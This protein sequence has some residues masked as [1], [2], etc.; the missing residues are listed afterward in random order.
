MFRLK[1]PQLYINEIFSFFLTP[2]TSFSNKWKMHII[3]LHTFI[4]TW[5]IWLEAREQFLYPER[6]KSINLKIMTRHLKDFSSLFRVRCNKNILSWS[7]SSMIY[8]TLVKIKE[9][10]IL[11]FMI[12]FALTISFKFFWKNSF[13]PN[14]SSFK[15][16]G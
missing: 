2:C 7:N 1:W 13:C 6:R 12:Y 14:L 3:H 15:D 10:L 5:Q 9:Y 16:I 11:R 8:C 4:K